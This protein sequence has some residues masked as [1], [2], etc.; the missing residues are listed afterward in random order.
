MRYAKQAPVIG[1]A[2]LAVGW[3]ACIEPLETIETKESDVEAQNT[4]H[5]VL[6]EIALSTNKREFIEIYNPGTTAQDLSNYYLSDDSDYALLPGTF[7]AGPAPYI[8]ATYDFIGKFPDGASIAAGGVAVVAMRYQGFEE[9]YGQAPD[10]AF[11]EVTDA[12][13]AMVDPGTDAGAQLIGTNVQLSN[14]SEGIVLFY[15]DGESDLV[16]DVDMV[17]AGKN[18]ASYNRLAD[19]T[20]LS[21]DGPDTDADTSTYADDSPSGEDWEIRSDAWNGTSHKRIAMEADG[22]EDQTGGGNGITGD[23]ETSEKYSLTWDEPSFTAP[24]PGTIPADL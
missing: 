8:N 7:G 10:F 18:P 14:D 4:S 5:L 6:T 3:M 11:L 13:K 2:F 24:T 12:S 1:M 23:D 17:T 22:E 20:G 19:K 16:A 9:K 15:W 21:V